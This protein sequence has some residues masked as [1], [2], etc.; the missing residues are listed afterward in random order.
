MKEAAG[1]GRTKGTPKEKGTHR[2]RTALY[3]I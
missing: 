3:R 1:E 2:Y